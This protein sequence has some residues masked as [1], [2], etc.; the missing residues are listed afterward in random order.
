[1]DPEGLQPP[2]QI[3]SSLG[4]SEDI[5]KVSKAQ[6]NPLTSPYCSSMSPFHPFSTLPLLMLLLSLGLGWNKAL[7]QVFGWRPLAQLET[8]KAREMM[9]RGVPL[10]YAW[11]TRQ[12]GGT[13]PLPIFLLQRG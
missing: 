1:M 6:K 8:V 7:K 4:A 12:G 3:G 11:E 5:F 2:F 9:G 10:P 13:T